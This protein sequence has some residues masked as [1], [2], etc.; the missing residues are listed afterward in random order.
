[1]ASWTR[2][3]GRDVAAIEEF[4][5]VVCSGGYDGPA[6]DMRAVELVRSVI[7]HQHTV[8]AETGELGLAEDAAAY[9]AACANAVVT[10]DSVPV[11]P[12]PEPRTADEPVRR[13]VA[14]MQKHLRDELAIAD[15]AAAGFVSVRT[16]QMAFRHHLHTTPMA[17][18]RELRLH[19]AHDELDQCCA[20]DGC[21]VTG[22]AIE[23]G[24]GH[25]GRFAA[26]Y[27]HLY[28]QS[29]RTTLNAPGSHAVNA[30]RP[31]S[32]DRLDP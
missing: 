18:L 20:G 23:L 8:E 2:F 17:Y 9:L 5:R 12:P 29:P 26:A 19:A 16:I 27:R 6:P 30:P 22:I 7:A 28:G 1:M 10:A 3:S 4:L 25:P 11:E 15:I 32:Q 13:A 24:F 21:T 14:F 31:E